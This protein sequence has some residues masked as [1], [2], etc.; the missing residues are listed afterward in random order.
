M[1]RV[2]FDQILGHP[3][4]QAKYT[5]LTIIGNLI[6]FWPSFGSEQ[7]SFPDVSLY[8]HTGACNA[9][10]WFGMLFSPLAHLRLA[11]RSSL[12]FC[13]QVSVGNFW[14]S[15][16]LGLQKSPFLPSAFFLPPLLLIHHTSVTAYG[17]LNFE[18]CRGITF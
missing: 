8:L 13:N 16:F 5:K 6:I 14:F 2:I 7:P 11:Q 1:F 9:H 15:G 3:I 10:S 12:H 4:A 17:C 18:V